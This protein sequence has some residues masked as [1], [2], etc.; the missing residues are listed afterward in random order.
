MDFKTKLP[1]ERRKM[2]LEQSILKYPTKVPMI[3]EAA[4]EYPVSYWFSKP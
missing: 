1:L 4:K 3:I 2:L